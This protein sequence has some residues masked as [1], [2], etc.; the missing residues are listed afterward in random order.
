VCQP[1]MSAGRTPSCID[2]DGIDVFAVEA[3]ATLSVTWNVNGSIDASGAF[4]CRGGRRGSVTTW[5][6]NRSGSTTDIFFA[7]AE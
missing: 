2:S 6:E 7:R 3:N 1:E 4:A 5:E